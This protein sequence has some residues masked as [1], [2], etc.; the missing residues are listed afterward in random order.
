MF[1]LLL[2][3]LLL[4]YPAP[5]IDPLKP[6]LPIG[7]IF[8]GPDDFAPGK[9]WILQRVQEGK[10]SAEPEYIVKEYYRPGMK[11]DWVRTIPE[12]PTSL[13]YLKTRPRIF[14]FKIEED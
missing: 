6:E 5:K 9:I 12:F 8:E 7:A 3:I 14:D 2:S 10:W 4:L 1:S 11:P 13:R